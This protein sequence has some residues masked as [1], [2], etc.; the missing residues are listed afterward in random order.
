[1]SAPERYFMVLLWDRLCYSLAEQARFVP[2]AATLNCPLLYTAP[3]AENPPQ[4]IAELRT[5]FNFLTQCCVLASCVCCSIAIKRRNGRIVADSR[6][7][8]QLY[9]RILRP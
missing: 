4:F 7:V 2:V 6:T 5:V 9:S 8:Q 3:L 1:M